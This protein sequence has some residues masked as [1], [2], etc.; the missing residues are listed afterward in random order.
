MLVSL[1]ATVDQL[2]A[3]PLDQLEILFS[4]LL[5]ASSNGIHCIVIDRRICEWAKTNL[6]LNGRELAQLTRLKA[7]YA[8]KGSLIALA[9][10]LLQVEV[11]DLQLSEG[12]LHIYTIGH[13]QFIRGNF[14]EDA[15]LLV[16]HIANDGD[17]INL[18]LGQHS[19]KHP[20]KSFNMQ[21]MHGGG[22]DI[23]TCFGIEIPK[24]HVIVGLVDSDKFAPSDQLSTTRRRM[25]AQSERQTYIGMTCELPCREIENLI[26]FEII[27]SHMGR[28][29]PQYQSF[30]ELSD[31]IQA[32]VIGGKS[33][34]LWMY[35][36][37]KKG[38]QPERLNRVQDANTRDW[39]LARFGVT[40]DDFHEVSI[41]GFGDGL[42]R[43]FLGCGE[44][45]KDFVTFMRGRH[46]RFH[47]E[48]FFDLIYWYFASEKRTR[49]I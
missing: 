49:I 45:V 24:Q 20:V 44:A 21:I 2:S 11:G 32:E 31:L 16:E 35:L 6:D 23:A 26:P 7:E 8:E 47:F 27:R 14:L 9:K 29:C 37:L 13:M 40:G 39:L 48:D 46:W 36:D 15:R 17:M 33:D 19:R 5:R 38:I 18:I 10:C 41:T 22:A 30:D 34:S 28:I 4:E 42:L 25:D 12:P 43:Q 1:N 3:T